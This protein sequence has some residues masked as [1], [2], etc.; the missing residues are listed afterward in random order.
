MTGFAV[1]LRNLAGGYVT[2]L[3]A[4]HTGIEGA[5]DFELSFT[6]QFALAIAGSD[7]VTL[8]NALDKQLGLKLALETVPSAVLVVDSVNDVP[9]PNPSGASYDVAAPPP[10]E[11]DV[12]SIKLSPPELTVST[13]RI[14][15]GGRIDLQGV[16]LQNL[17]MVAWEINDP[18]LLAGGPDWLDKTRYSINALATSSV[19]GSGTDMQIDISDLDQMLKALLIER[20]QLK[21]HMED[22]PV[23]AYTLVADKPK[24]QPGKPGDRT[25]WKNGPAPNTNDP[26]NRNPILS[27]LVTVQN[28]TMAEF[29]DVL[30]PIAPGYLR[31][32]VADETGLAG[33]WNFTFNFSPVGAVQPAARP[34]DG[35]GGAGASDPTG[36]ISLFD[37]VNK[38]L[39]L[40]LEMRKRSMPVLVIDKVEQQPID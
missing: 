31:L 14:Q 18:Q 7:G 21:T 8:P 3:L 20:F 30:Q 4:N 25:R 28:M 10:A 38:Q 22:R 2:E 24:L 33:R 27:R 26:R 16:T 34:A 29:A 36:A 6:P 17:I 35:T 19:S 23:S 5:F 37:A 11:F 40:K 39:G 15:P 13:G 32:P 12:A 1:I 9:I